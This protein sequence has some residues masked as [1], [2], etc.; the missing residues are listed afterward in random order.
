MCGV[1]LKDRKQSKD[2]NNLLDI[3][4]VADVVRCGRLRWFVHMEHYNVDDWVSACKSVEVTGLKC[5]GRGRKIWGE[6]VNDDM[7]LL[8][9]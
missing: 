8:S 1:S 7:K 6:C 5:R 2:L 4:S 9:L 3:Q